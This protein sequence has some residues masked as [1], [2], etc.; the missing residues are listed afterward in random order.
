M[1]VIS[2]AKRLTEN[3]R[4][5]ALKPTTPF[6]KK[7][8]DSLANELALMSSEEIG[9][10]MKVSDGIA[11]LNL[12]RFKNWNKN[13]GSEKRA[14]F[15]FE[16][17]VFKHL[18]A[19][20]FND[21]QTNYMNKNL[22]ILSG[23]YGLLRPSDEMSPYR[24]EM[25]TKHNFDGSKNLYEF[26]GDKIAKKIN[27]ELEDSLLF[28]LASQE[29]FSAISKYVNSEKTVNFRFL[30]LTGGKERVVGVV[31]KRARGEMARFLIENQIESTDGIEEFSSIGFRFKELSNNCFTFV[32]S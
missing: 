29:Y 3:V 31:A 28:N 11:E 5:S 9:S 7:E 8:A 23:I 16:G 12:D 24:L 4:D 10:L 13:M 17:D 22:K 18:N 21:V 25:G 32:S 2:P 26:W 20:K 6:F 14:I 19:G 1:I 27:N 30:S 15:Q